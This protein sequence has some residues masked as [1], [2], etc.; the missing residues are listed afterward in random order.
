MGKYLDSAGL[1]HVWDKIKDRTNA[2]KTEILDTKG[3][4][5]GIASLD[6]NGKIPTSQLPSIDT[7]LYVIMEELPTADNAAYRKYQNKIMLVKDASQ[8]GDSILAVQ[9]RYIEYV[10][11]QGSRSVTNSDGTSSMKAYYW[12]EKFGEIQTDVDLSG[13]LKK[14]E[15]AS[16]TADGAMSKSDKKNLDR[17]IGDTYPFDI[18]SFAVNP[19]LIAVGSSL[20]ANLS[21]GYKN[22]DFHPLKSQTVND[23]AVDNSATTKAV[24]VPA[25]TKHKT[26]TFTLKAI[27]TDGAQ[28]TKTANMYV[29]HN[30]Y[31]GVAGASA[32]TLDATAIKAGTKSLEWG[33]VKTAKIAQDNQ[34]AWYAYPAYFGDLSSIKNSS[35]FEGLGGYNKLTVQVDGQ[36][37]TVYLQKDA[38]TATDTYTFK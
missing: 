34:K 17:I 23:E 31:I 22:L 30:S 18:T 4:N 15:L 36:D 35:G 7:T 32:T 25:Q 21:W 29:N 16:Q 13:Y 20:S 6:A 24:T 28:K 1:S 19:S 33:K 3:K 12:W 2:V 38:A 11:M 5:N 26:L 8:S 27:A 37:Y 9:N 10:I 14:N